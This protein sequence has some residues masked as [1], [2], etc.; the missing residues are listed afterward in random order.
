MAIERKTKW[1]PLY[2]YNS[3]GTDRMVF[4]RKG[5]RTGILY[6]RSKVVAGVINT[7]YAFTGEEYDPKKQIDSLD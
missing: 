6:F 7:S 2:A 4:V 5:L 1:V 3:S